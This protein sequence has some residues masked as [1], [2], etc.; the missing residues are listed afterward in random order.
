MIG[1]SVSATTTSGRGTAS[2]ARQDEPKKRQVVRRARGEAPRP[3]RGAPRAQDP[4]AVSLLAPEREARAAPGLGRRAGRPEQRGAGHDPDLVTA[5][6]REVLGEVREELARGALVRMIRAVEEADA[7]A[8]RAPGRHSDLRPL[9]ED[10]PPQREGVH[11]RAEEAVEG[12][13]GLSARW[14]RSR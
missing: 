9:D 2:P 12:L 8:R 1:G 7:Q 5:V 4:H 14:A 6:A 3:E 13:L 10:G 11:A